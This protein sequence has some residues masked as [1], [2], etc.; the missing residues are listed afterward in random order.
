M[1]G[2]MLQMKVVPTLIVYSVDTL[3]TVVIC[4]V[5]VLWILSNMHVII[6]NV[7]QYMVERIHQNYALQV[8]FSLS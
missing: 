4:I 6:V 8:T 1:F 5:S 2:Y 7:L 3:W